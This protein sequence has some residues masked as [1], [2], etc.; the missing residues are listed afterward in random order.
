MLAWKFN[1]QWFLNLDLP[2]LLAQA[3]RHRTGAILLVLTI[4]MYQSAGIFYKAVGLMLVRAKSSAP[5]MQGKAG[6]TPAAVMEPIDA[7]KVIADK[8]LFGTTDKTLA[9]KQA[10]SQGLIG[11]SDLAAALEVRGT[12]AG[13][14][15]YG[16]AVIEDKKQKKQKLYK[17][18]D[19]VSGAKVVRIMRNAVAFRIDDR[20]QLLRVPETTEKG[21][22]PFTASGRAPSPEA[23]PGGTIAINRSD[24]EGSLKD[25][26]TMLS[27]AQLR[28]YFTAGKPDGFMISNIRGGSLYQKIGLVDGDII[29]A[30]NERKLA[31]GDNMVE[32]YN[33]FK[34][35]PGMSIKILRQGRQ[36]N[37][38]YTFR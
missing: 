15:R 23:G 3:T 2:A 11:P 28:P 7:F 32:L 25:M 16:F 8:N 1:R 14:A 10:L 27:Q 9:D 22:L 26:G 18:G 12:V 6:D 34:S 24:I 30:F 4:L 21:V 31:S 35:S 20:E 33:Q 19:I 37:L 13:E 38:N 5:A 17:V 29:Q 36:Q